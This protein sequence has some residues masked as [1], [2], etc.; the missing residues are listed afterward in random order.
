MINDQ[1]VLV[2]IGSKR[3]QMQGQEHAI[4]IQIDL[5]KIKADE[6][7]VLIIEMQEGESKVIDNNKTNT[8]LDHNKLSE[9]MTTKL[10]LD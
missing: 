2:A 6:K 1:G 4:K 9:Q 5:I 10:S 7:T 8:D 3:G